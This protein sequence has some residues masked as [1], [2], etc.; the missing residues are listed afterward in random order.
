MAATAQRPGRRRGRRSPQPTPAASR[1]AAACRP[2]RAARAAPPVEPPPEPAK[3]EPSR[4]VHSRSPKSQPAGRT[5]ARGRIA[6]AADVEAGAARIGAG[7]SVGRIGRS[8]RRRCSPRGRAS[9]SA[10]SQQPGQQAAHQRLPPGRGQ[11]RDDRPRLSREPGVPARHR[12]AQA[13]D[14]R[15]GDRPGPRPRRSGALRGHEHRAGRA[16][17]RCRGRNGD[18]LVEQARRIFE[19]DLVDVAEVD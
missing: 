7:G 14:A 4:R 10:I 3:S 9:S 19:D 2:S 6:A 8:A 13:A 15:G 5:D 18:D 17:R 1:P 12:R 16:S 11:R